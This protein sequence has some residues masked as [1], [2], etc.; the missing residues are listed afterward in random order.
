MQTY[1]FHVEM[2]CDGCSGALNRI[3]TRQKGSF[4]KKTF[5]AY[6]HF[7]SLFSKSQ[8]QNFMLLIFLNIST[9]KGNVSA[10]E[11]D[12]AGKLVSVTTPLTMTEV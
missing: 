1:K 10:Y 3:L 5:N 7:L 2:T 6:F 8:V 4:K 12:L 11:V 9:E